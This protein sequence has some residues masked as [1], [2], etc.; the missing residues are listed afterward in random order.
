LGRAVFLVFLRFGEAAINSSLHGIRERRDLSGLGQGLD[1]FG[2][3]HVADDKAVALHT[4][5]YVLIELTIAKGWPIL[6]PQH[7][8]SAVNCFKPHRLSL[9][10]AAGPQRGT[11]NGAS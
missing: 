1:P 9:A 3:Q 11:H 6:P 7:E 8:A 4:F 5:A 2:E 10:F